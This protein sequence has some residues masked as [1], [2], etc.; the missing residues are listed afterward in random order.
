MISGLF[1]KGRIFRWRVAQGI[2]LGVWG[3]SEVGNLNASFKHHHRGSITACFAGEGEGGCK[4]SVGGVVSSTPYGLGARASVLRVPTLIS[5]NYSVRHIA[6]VSVPV[7]GRPG[8]N[9]TKEL[10]YG[11]PLSGRTSHVSVWEDSF[12][13]VASD[14]FSGG[15]HGAGTSCSERACNCENHS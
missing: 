13:A 6:R 5:W 2:F 15:A 12:A 11:T 4:A 3:V 14:C 10:T 7:D 8:S 1:V 9:L